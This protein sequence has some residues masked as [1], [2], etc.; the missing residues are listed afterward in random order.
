MN[1]DDNASWPHLSYH[2]SYSPVDTLNPFTQ[3]I[4]NPPRVKQLQLSF[5]KHGNIEA[6]DRHIEEPFEIL[7]NS[8]RS[9]MHIQENISI[10]IFHPEQQNC[11]ILVA[12]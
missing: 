7:N 5:E 12:I 9:L 10:S 3:A 8:V 4:A 6:Q 1:S 11:S 2:N